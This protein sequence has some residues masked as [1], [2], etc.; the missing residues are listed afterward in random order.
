MKLSRPTFEEQTM[1]KESELA[2]IIPPKPLLPTQLQE[3]ASENQSWLE[4]MYQKHKLHEYKWQIE[5]FLN[6]EMQVDGDFTYLNELE[7]SD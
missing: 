6:S 2:Q 5:S 4:K 3:G 7:G 1:F